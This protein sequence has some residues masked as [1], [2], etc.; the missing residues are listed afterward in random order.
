[1]NQ[2]HTSQRPRPHDQ[3]LERAEIAI[4]Y[5]LR[6]GV[7]VCALVLGIGWFLAVTGHGTSLVD[8]KNVMSGG[9]Q[10]AVI[11]PHSSAEL[12]QKLAGLDSVTWIESGLFLLILLPISRVFLAMVIFLFERNWKFVLFSFIVLAVLIGS[13]INGN[14]T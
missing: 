8:F 7:I 2:L 4:A 10:V 13:M 1:M 6:Y 3:Q 11:F 12:F 14:A 9:H 5:L